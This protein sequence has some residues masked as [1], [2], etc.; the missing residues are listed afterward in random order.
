MKGTH[1]MAVLPSKDEWK[2]KERKFNDQ[3]GIQHSKHR[4]LRNPIPE[5][6]LFFTCWYLNVLKW[7]VNVPINWIKNRSGCGNVKIVA[8]SWPSHEFEADERDDGKCTNCF[9]FFYPQGKK[10]FQFREGK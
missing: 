10:R 4:K 2:R 5:S 3:N 8:G 1:R 6:T 9:C 7:E